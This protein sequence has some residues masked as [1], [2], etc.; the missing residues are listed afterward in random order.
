VSFFVSFPYGPSTPQPFVVSRSVLSVR[1]PDP[2]SS[3]E[4]GALLDG[5][6]RIDR[7]VGEGGIGVVVVATHEHLEQ[8]VAVKYL[9]AAAC[10]Q[11]VLCERFLREA[12]L[13]AKLQSLH[14]VRVHDVGEAPCGTPYMVMEYLEGEDLGTRVERGPTPVGVAVDWV[15]QTCEAL[16]EMHAL[17]FVHRDLKPENLFLARTSSGTSMVKL[18]DFGISKVLDK[19]PQSKRQASLTGVTERFGTPQYMP[20]EQLGASANVDARADIWA[21]GVVLHELVTGAPPFTGESI[22]E[23]CASVLLAPY[24]GLAGACAPAGLE[25]VL[26]KCLAK[27]PQERFRNVAELARALAPFG[28]AGAMECARRVA[29]VIRRGGESVRPDPSSL[30]PVGAPATPPAELARHAPT[31]AAWTD[32]P[33][34]IASP[35]ASAWRARA[36]LA[37]GAAALVALVVVTFAPLASFVRSPSP[38]APHGRPFAA[39]PEAAASE[40]S[41]TVADPPPPEPPAT[42]RSRAT[43]P[44]SATKH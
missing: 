24:P 35:A 37:V 7:V 34:L 21:A 20:P 17:G 22:P 13:G 40:T 33:D 28:P 10:R 6:Y 32:A 1:S 36:K 2:T 29:T 38:A 4:P 9:K 43:K 25:G 42:A 18:L 3:F 27:K 15:L 30:A 39:S 44:R 31:L 23:I 19:N 12:R 26:R 8:R 16:A 5:K 11:P 14:V 41:W